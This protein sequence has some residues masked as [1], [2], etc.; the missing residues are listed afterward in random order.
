MAGG[1][2]T[3]ITTIVT[4]EDLQ[5]SDTEEDKMIMIIVDSLIV[6]TDLTTEKIGNTAPIHEICHDL[7]LIA[8]IGKILDIGPGNNTIG[9]DGQCAL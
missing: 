7:D 8:D 2:K 3:L 6:I 4:D 9:H 1:Q 5:A